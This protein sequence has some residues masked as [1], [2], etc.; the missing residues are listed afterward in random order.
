MENR[1]W[2]KRKYPKSFDKANDFLND[3][4]LKNFKDKKYKLG[5][6]LEDINEGEVYKKGELCMFKRTNPINDYNYPLHTIIVKCTEGLT[7]SGYH[8]FW[9][10]PDKIEEIKE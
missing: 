4:W 6:L 2:L 5:K 9:I 7:A 10:F 3:K 1:K 8:S